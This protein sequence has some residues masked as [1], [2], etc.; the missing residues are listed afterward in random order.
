MTQVY[1]RVI[2]GAFGFFDSQNRPVPTVKRSQDVTLVVDDNVWNS[3][4]TRIKLFNFRSYYDVG[5]KKKNSKAWCADPPDL[6]KNTN[7]LTLKPSSS[8][9]WRRL[10]VF[11]V[12]V[13][14]GK[15]SFT[16]TDPWDESPG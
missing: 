13:T 11:D 1:A 10:I 3:G 12:T 16:Y 2:D 5:W 9:A 14:K 4:I 7:S 15:T 8:T 6:T